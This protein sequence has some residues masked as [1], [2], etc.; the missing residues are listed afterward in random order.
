MT[1]RS[2]RWRLPSFELNGPTALA[3]AAVVGTFLA[4]AVVLGGASAAGITANAVL[5]VA[6]VVAIAAVSMRRWS[7]PLATGERQLLVLFALLVLLYVAQ[8]VPLP[9]DLWQVLPGRRTVTAGLAAL[10]LAP[11]AMPLSLAPAL[12]LH[13]G[14]ALLPPLA[15]FV[16]V[17]RFQR[18]IGRVAIATL[19]GL[20]LVSVLLGVAQFSGGGPYVYRITN[21]GNATGFF[22][23]SNHFATLMCMGMPL[24]AALV[25]R[26]RVGG[27][28]GHAAASR[29]FAIVVLLGVVLL[30]LLGIAMTGSVAGL[31]L[32]VVAVIGSAAIVLSG[33][34]RR[35]R[36]GLFAAVLLVIVLAG[37][38][39]FSGT[40]GGFATTTT[41]DDDLSR[42]AMWRATVQAIRVFGAA[43]TGFGSFAQ[44]FHLFEDPAKVSTH[45]TNH[46]HND[47]LEFLLEGGIPG[48]VLLALFLA[49]FAYRVLRV[50]VLDRRRDPLAQ[51][52]AIAALV[53][54]LHSLVDYPMRTSAI[55]TVFALCL[56]LL[57]RGSGGGAA[58]SEEAPAEALPGRHLSA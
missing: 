47:L 46:A 50:W 17:A 29:A 38:V 48:V 55:A 54:L 26:W 49:W 8:S 23:N 53:V 30:G 28:D 45:F 12:T 25:A 42:P 31:L 20:M 58:T 19:L 27:S 2:T 24:A 43:G 22:A 11:S 6:A 15:M 4:G 35:V 13:S 51:G 21:G 32:S 16:M 14:V 40:I 41:G 44:V 9:P 34:P 3:Q 5:Q 1:S 57:A 18:P 37:A 36:L 39:V 10:G 33:L 7:M 56:A 52:A